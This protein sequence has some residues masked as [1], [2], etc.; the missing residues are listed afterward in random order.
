MNFKCLLTFKAH[1]LFYFQQM[2]KIIFLLLLPVF[3]FSQKNYDYRNLVLEGGGVRGLAYAGAFK[4]L[5]EKSVLQNIERIGGSS[6]GAIAGMMICIGYSVEEID[7]IMMDLPVEKFNDGNGGLV[8]KYTRFKKKY[9]LYKGDAFEKWLTKMV[10]HK[11]GDPGFTFNQLH[12]LHLQNN[13]YKDLYCTATNLSKQRLEV[14]SYQSTPDL[15]IALAVRISAGIPLYF[16]PV[17]LDD[18]FN[19]IKKSD[20]AVAVNY[21]VDGGMLCNYPIG[22]FD[23]CTYCSAPLTCDKAVFNQ[24]TIGIKLESPQQ[25]DSLNNNSIN[26]PPYN[27]NKYSEYLFAFANL[28]MEQLSRKYPNLE[29]ELG[30]TIYVSQGKVISKIKKTSVEDKRLLYDNGVKGATEFFKTREANFTVQ[31]VSNYLYYL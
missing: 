24:H 20:T 4:V 13:L 16:E 21:Y 12:Q 9:G 3:A 22:M 23:S 28:L 11:T 7:S 18:H 8:G 10:E 31:L 14:F 25:I 5:E 27:I 15:P 30:R 26:I 17:I 1:L 6:A 29:N 19:K 2:K